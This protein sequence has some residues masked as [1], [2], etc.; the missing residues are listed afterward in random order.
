MQPWNVSNWS[1]FLILG[2]NGEG[3]VEHRGLVFSHISRAMAPDCSN[4][5][6][7]ACLVWSTC[8][9]F[10]DYEKKSPM[11][12]V[13][14]CFLNIQSDTI[15]IKFLVVEMSKRNNKNGRTPNSGCPAMSA[16]H[17]HHAMEYLRDIP[18][19][20][21][22]KEWCL[23]PKGVLHVKTIYVALLGLRPVLVVVCSIW[24]IDEWSTSKNCPHRCC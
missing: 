14:S 23:G 21:S 10:R 20:R 17:S 22:S 13:P 3:K 6:Y 8:W 5:L 18:T 24:S 11:R 7:V 16:L 15:M 4:H 12:W 2:F 9:L 1:G 19:Q